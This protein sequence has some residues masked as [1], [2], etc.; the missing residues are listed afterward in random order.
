M[1]RPG[2][3][4]RWLS[5]LLIL[6]A[7]V[8]TILQLIRFSR[9]RSNFPPGLTIAG[10][11]VG[12]LDNQQA[13]S[14]LLQVYSIPV[15]IHYA[16]AVIQIKPALV[17]FNLD[18]NGML[19]A[20]DI[21]RLDQPFWQAFWDYL[22]NRYPPPAQ[23]PLLATVSEERLKTYLQTE[24]AARYDRP[25]T[26]AM[27]IP[28]SVNFKPGLPGTRL[29]LDRAVLLIKDALQSPTDRVVN[30]TYSKASPSRPSLQNLQILMQQII[31]QNRFDG[32]TEI[33]FLDL[34]TGQ[35][36]NFAYQNGENIPPEIAFTAGSTI[37]I[38]VMVTA[39]RLLADPIPQ[40]RADLLASM[41]ERSDN[42]STDALIKTVMDKNLGPLEVTRTM[43]DLG[44][45]NTFLAG[46]FSPG[47]PLLE[48]Y[49]TPGNQRTDVNTE[50][51][52]Y[53]QTSPADMGA[54]LD[55]IYQCS[56][57]GGGS[58]AAVYPGQFTQAKC[59]QMIDYLIL[60]KTPQLIK[61]GLPDGVQVAHKHGWLMETDGYIHHMADAAIVYSAGG[62]YILTIYLYH[63]VQL[64]FD[65][66]NL[67]VAQIS[68]AVYNYFNTPNP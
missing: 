8:V 28:G 34:Q 49:R 15:E 18:L 61:A 43:Q 42:Q 64:V 66:V 31:T 9:L 57:T 29:D 41:I 14:R 16:E 22:W 24:I 19:T 63:P 23:I 38:P 39:F 48:R 55:D 62:N 21:Q 36:L 65:P 56:I 17:G 2:S 46:Y 10:V 30:L 1:N 13:A 59:K 37:K 20:A 45:A 35:E 47:S 12:N 40:A 68:S 26:P 58:L 7:V 60:N 54:L 67:M 11:P 44:L 52:V 32:L 53:N 27:P 33:Y 25:P 5:I 3:F 4:L 6:L 51:D 50:P